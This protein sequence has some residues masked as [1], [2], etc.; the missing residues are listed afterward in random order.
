VLCYTQGKIY[1]RIHNGNI[2]KREK[3]LSN[4][5]QTFDADVVIDQSNHHYD[6][7][8]YPNIVKLNAL[9]DFSNFARNSNCQT[10]QQQ[11]FEN[12]GL[13]QLPIQY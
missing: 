8:A 13:R 6:N 3:E 12:H 4:S 5:L 10:R 2:K 7:L 1:I 9:F 11:Q